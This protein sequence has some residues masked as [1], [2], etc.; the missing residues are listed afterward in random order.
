[1][2]KQSIMLF[3]LRN[4][5]LSESLNI[6][7]ELLNMAVDFNSMR[8][9]CLLIDFIGNLCLYAEDCDKSVFFFEQLRIACTYNRNHQL[10]VDALVG[11]ARNATKLKMYKESHILLKK[12]LQYTWAV[13]N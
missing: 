3:H 12:A 1:M 11:L 13:G 7:Y 8:F 9:L 10:K 4:D 6:A 2:K 5:E